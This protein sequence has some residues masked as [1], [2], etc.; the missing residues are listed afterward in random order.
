MVCPE[1]DNGINLLGSGNDLF[2]IDDV[3]STVLIKLEFE[4][5]ELAPYNLPDFVLLKLLCFRCD[6]EHDDEDEDV[7]LL[8]DV[9]FS[10]IQQL[11]LPLLLVLLV[12]A[13]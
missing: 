11:A 12:R 6:D 5:F 9:L 7:C 1:H 13:F 2:T 10:L 3:A 4:S 8:F